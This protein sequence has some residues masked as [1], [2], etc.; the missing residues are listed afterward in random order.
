MGGW[1]G[2]VDR[3]LDYVEFR[4]GGGVAMCIYRFVI[5]EIDGYMRFMFIDL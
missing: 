4:D 1:V 2:K 5:L 3:V